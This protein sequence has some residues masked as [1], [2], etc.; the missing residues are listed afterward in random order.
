[1]KALLL[2]TLI[3]LFSCISPKA[4]QSEGFYIEQEKIYHYSIYGDTTL[5]D[6]RDAVI[7]RNDTLIQFY[8]N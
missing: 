7:L 3:I 8:E 6:K 2:L 1:M 5:I 4:F